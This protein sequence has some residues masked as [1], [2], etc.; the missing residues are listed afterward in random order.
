MFLEIKSSILMFL[1]YLYFNICC[2]YFF[3]TKQKNKKYNIENNEKI[4]HLFICNDIKLS[5]IN[6]SEGIIYL[7][8]NIIK[9][10]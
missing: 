10:N 6:S 8:F 5:T 3:F 7:V 1:I 4:K 9:I 2:L